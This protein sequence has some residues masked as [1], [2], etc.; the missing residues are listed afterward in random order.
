MIVGHRWERDYAYRGYKCVPL[1]FGGVESHQWCIGC[2]CHIGD[3]EVY[4]RRMPIDE[5]DRKVGKY[6]MS[7]WLD[8]LAEERGHKPV[9]A[10]SFEEY[11]LQLALQNAQVYN[12]RS[13]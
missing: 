1:P 5:I 8:M 13:N 2:D 11:K 6:Q 3:I 9:E 10:G 12:E 7:I 4:S